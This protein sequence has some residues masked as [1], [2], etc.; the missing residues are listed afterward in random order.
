MIRF[1]TV[2]NSLNLADVIFKNGIG[3]DAL[4]APRQTQ[5]WSPQTFSSST[6]PRRPS[7]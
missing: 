5:T 1:G 3:Y 6:M 2:G 7:R 4:Y